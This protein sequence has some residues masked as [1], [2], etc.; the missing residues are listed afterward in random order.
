MI[1][2]ASHSGSVTAISLGVHGA[3]ARRC[4]I[5]PARVPL[6]LA[7][8]F[9]GTGSCAVNLASVAPPTDKHLTTATYAKENPAR[10]FIKTCV[11]AS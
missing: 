1:R 11:M 10:N 5:A 9:L 2:H 6:L 7:T 3:A 4:L 8:G